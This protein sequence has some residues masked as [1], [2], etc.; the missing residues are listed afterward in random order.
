[1]V[2]QD[3][4]Y[5][6]RVRDEKDLRG[7]GR[8]TSTKSKTDVVCSDVICRNMGGET[9]TH[10]QLHILFKSLHYVKVKTTQ[11]GLERGFTDVVR[12]GRGC[13]TFSKLVSQSSFKD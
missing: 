12:C 3:V 1:M 13:Y 4:G 2:L 10:I 8:G 6:V 11:N 5:S 7:R 9:C